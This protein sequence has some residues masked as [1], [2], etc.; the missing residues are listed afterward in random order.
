MSASAWIRP[1]EIGFLGDGEFGAS[2]G[3]RAPRTLRF[4]AEQGR[5]V[6]CALG[7]AHIRVGV[8]ALD[9][10]ILEHTH[11]TWDIAQGPEKTIDAVMALVDDVLKKD[12]RSARLG[13]G[14]GPSRPG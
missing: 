1:F 13:C 7:A 10:D 14:G 8:T 3:G 2:S 5:I 12:H 11:R 9:G 4:R 6:I